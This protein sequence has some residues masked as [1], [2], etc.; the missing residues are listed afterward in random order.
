MLEGYKLRRCFFGGGGGAEWVKTGKRKR[1]Y[2]SVNM[3]VSI[4]FMF[5]VLYL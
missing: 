5:V 4:G 3:N 1:K 2:M